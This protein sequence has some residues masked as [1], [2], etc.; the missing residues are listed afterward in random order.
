MIALA[1]ADIS[2]GSMGSTIQIC[3]IPSGARR[4]FAAA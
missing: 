3:M 2:M 1:K 4:F